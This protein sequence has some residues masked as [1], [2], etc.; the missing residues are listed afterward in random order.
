[1]ETDDGEE[2][3]LRACL[4]GRAYRQHEY[5]S[6]RLLYP[7]KRTGPRGEGKF[8]RISWDEAFDEVAKGI[9]HIKDTY[10][11]QAISAFVYSGKAAG[12]FHLLHTGRQLQTLFPGGVRPWGG[13]SGEGSVFSARATYGTLSTS[14]TRDDLVNSKLILLWGMDPA[15]SVFATNT[16][17]YLVN[18]REAGARIISIDPKYTDTAATMADQWIPIRPSTDAAL[19]I[20]MAYVII[21]E[22]LHDQGFLDKYTIGFDQ[23]KGYLLGEEDDIPKTAEWASSKTGVPVD[24]IV[25]LAREYATLHPAALLAGFAPGRTAFGEQYH[26]AVSSLAAMTGNV[27]IHGGDAAGFHRGPVG[28]ML[29]TSLGRPIVNK[30]KFDIPRILRKT[31]HITKIWDAINE[32]T[33][34]GYPTDL[35]MLYLVGVNPLNQFPNI[36]KGVQA[37]QKLEFIII[38][39]QFMTSTARFADILLPASTVWERNDF[40]RPWMSGPYWLYL[41]KVVDPPGEVKSDLDI[42]CEIGKRLGI[43][44]PAFYV[45]EEEGIRQ[46]LEIQGDMQDV[47]ADLDKFRREGVYKIPVPEPQVS[48]QRQIEDPEHNPFPTTSGKIEIYCDLLA[49]LNDPLVPPIPKY[50]D[51]WEGPEDPLVRKYPLQMVTH[52]HKTRAHSNFHNVPWLRELEPQSIWISTHDARAR[53][54]ADGEMVRVFNDRGET[55]I[56]AKVTER[57]M[58]GVVSLGQGAWYTPDEKGRDTA[59]SANILTADRHSPGGAMPCNTALVQVAKLQSLQMKSG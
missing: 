10:G 42:L 21:T 31:Y 38:H 8:E 39:E 17:Y 51:P 59:G 13:A 26:R 57:I 45:S 18:A 3:Q 50:L 36:N 27:G 32:G 58:P 46:Y 47:L 54:I 55:R 23:Y 33:A 5:S 11:D 40:S 48:F 44:D 52:H 20:G 2:P 12:V 1:V 28:P 53:G 24:T 19:A 7:Q 56:Q 34:G 22:N 49:Q 4:R 25:D 37:L 35:K 41:N 29:P 9:R 16:S 14:N 15:V 30:K 43:T 6:L